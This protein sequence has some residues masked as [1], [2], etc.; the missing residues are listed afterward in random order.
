MTWF[1]VG[2]QGSCPNIPWVRR[3]RPEIQWVR[4]RPPRN[5]VGIFAQDIYCQLI[6]DPFEFWLAGT[7]VQNE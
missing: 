4:S 3:D 1:P 7:V 6:P 2:R 5:Q